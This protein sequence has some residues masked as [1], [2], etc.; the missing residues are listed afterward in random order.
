MTTAT[1]STPVSPGIGGRLQTYHWI[2]QGQTFA[3][4][5][6]TLGQG[7][8]V[9]LLPAFSTVSSRGE[10]RGL[11]QPLA[12]QFQV[13]ALD[14]PGFGDS[15]RPPVNYHPALY[16]QFLQDF[17][18]AMFDQPWPWWRRVMPLAMGSNWG[19]SSL[20]FGRGWF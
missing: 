4:A 11:A 14:W 12:E 17:V 5:Y 1:V 15:S 19:N 20:L 8:P 6:E 18:G 13:F 7:S 10:M 2:W 9:L 3:I 16:H